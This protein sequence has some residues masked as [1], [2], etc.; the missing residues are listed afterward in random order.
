MKV[1]FVLMYTNIHPSFM[2]DGISDCV[3]ATRRK[4]FSRGCEDS[5]SKTTPKGEDVLQEATPIICNNFINLFKFCKGRTKP[6]V[7]NVGLRR[8]KP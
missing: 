4:H 1:N 8:G 3:P 6:Q 2:K 5:K 7:I